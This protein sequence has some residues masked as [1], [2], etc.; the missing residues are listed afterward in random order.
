[1]RKASRASFPLCCIYT[2]TS[3]PSR[4]CSKRRSYVGKK[5]GCKQETVQKDIIKESVVQVALKLLDNKLIDQVSQAVY[6]IAQELMIEIYSALKN[7][8]PPIKKSKRNLMQLLIDGKAKDL[9]LEKL[10]RLEKKRKEIALQ[11]DV[12]KS[13]MLDCKLEDFFYYVKR[14]KHFVYTK[15]ENRQAFI[16]TF[17]NRVTYLEVQKRKSPLQHNRL[18]FGFV[19]RPFGG[20]NRTRTCDLLHVKQAL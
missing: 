15:T 18:F 13:E 12:A 11:L 4:R 3:T 5:D 1:M 10:D 17:V 2:R 9:I 8:L 6:E 7:C 14:F 16:D 20:D 19:L